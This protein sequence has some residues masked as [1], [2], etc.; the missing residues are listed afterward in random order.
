M[1]LQPHLT[2]DL[3]EL[4]PLRPDDW[5]GLFAVASDPSIWA[6]HPARD[7][8]QE[9]VFSDY[10]RE[11]LESGGALVAIDRTT[12]QIIGASRY[13]WY[14]P[15]HNEL[16]IGWTFLARAYWGGVYNGEMKRVML[17]YAFRFVD[18][19][20]FLVG[21]G[22]IRSQKAVRKIGGILTE[23]RVSRTFHGESS[24]SVV[25]EIRKADFIGDTPNAV[26][27]G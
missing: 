16:E 25:F 1:D 10:F 9:P 27:T 26:R 17:A 21:T 22:N 11:A 3:L 6:G 18:R 13:F 12:R 24:E 2:G 7:R 15:N 8:Y 23:R 5:A 19:V 14:G 20:I 4:R